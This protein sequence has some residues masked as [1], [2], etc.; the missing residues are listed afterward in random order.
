M[1]SYMAYKVA[2]KTNLSYFKK[3]D[4]VVT[5]RFSDFLG[6]FYTYVDKKI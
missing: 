6:K 3:K 4:S 5:R 1:G 2:T